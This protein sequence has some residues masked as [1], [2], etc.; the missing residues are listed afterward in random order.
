M[1]A[2]AR[3]RVPNRTDKIPVRMYHLV[4]RVGGMT[5][6]LCIDDDPNIL[7]CHKAVLGTRGYTVVTAPDGL[8]GIAITRTHSIDIVITDFQM[9]GMDGSQVAEL[10]LK[11]KPRLPVLIC[12][13]CPDEIPARVRYG[14]YNFLSKGDG[15]S[16]LLAMVA[17]LL[18]VKVAMKKPTARKK[19]RAAYQKAS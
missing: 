8:A 9:P 15:P 5:T 14:V 16:D 1:C 11:E 19:S 6:I 17:K 13:G 18:T 2:S 12:S 3:L 4:N 10:L 7:Q